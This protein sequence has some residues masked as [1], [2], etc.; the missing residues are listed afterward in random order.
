M[1][2]HESVAQSTGMRIFFA[3]P[4][5]L[6]R[7]GSNENTIALLRLYFPNGTSLSGFDRADL[8]IVADSS[9]GRPRKTFDFATPSERFSGLMAERAR[10]NQDL[11]RAGLVHAV[12]VAALGAA[13]ERGIPLGQPAGSTRWLEG[14]RRSLTIT[15]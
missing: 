12:R 5:A 7:R 11:D 3:D 1:A 10:T 2:Q 8:D 15:T 9:N 6:W 13:S 14:G 4:H